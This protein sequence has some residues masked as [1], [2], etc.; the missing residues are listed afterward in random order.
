MRPAKLI[1][2]AVFFAAP[3][4]FGT[5]ATDCMAGLPAPSDEIHFEPES[6]RI[7]T[8]VYDYLPSTSNPFVFQRIDFA[9]TTAVDSGG[10]DLYFKPKQFF[11]IHLDETDLTGHVKQTAVES[12]S[13]LLDMDFLLRFLFFK[14]DV[15]VSTAAVFKRERATMPLLFKVPVNSKSLLMPGSGAFYSWSE[16]SARITESAKKCRESGCLFSYS[17]ELPPASGTAIPQQFLVRMDVPQNLVLQGFVPELVHDHRDLAATK[18]WPVV[19]NANAP[20]TGIYFEL[21]GLDKGNY[22]IQ[23]DIGLQT[24]PREAQ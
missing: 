4:F 17:G 12:G 13:V 14:I 7:T 11:N 19:R 16:R 8:A 9:G 10:L 3:A 15:N 6:R 21:S 5:T 23:Y 2:G 1:F 18:G 24:G 20:R 22:Q